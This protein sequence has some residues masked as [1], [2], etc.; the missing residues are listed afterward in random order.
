MINEYGLLFSKASVLKFAS[1]VIA[2][3]AEDHQLRSVVDPRGM[4]SACWVRRAVDV[5][6]GQ[7]L[8]R[9]L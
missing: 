5:P 1:K 4:I 8:R 6:L 2:L 9:D 7:W 3:V